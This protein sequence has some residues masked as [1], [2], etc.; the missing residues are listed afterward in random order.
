[1]RVC[2]ENSKPAC[3]EAQTQNSKSKLKTHRHVAPPADSIRSLLR[4]F[5][6]LLHAVAGREARR[7]LE[8]DA[9]GRRDRGVQAQQ[10]SRAGITAGNDDPDGSDLSAAEQG[11]RAGAAVEHQLQEEK[12]RVV[13]GLVQSRAL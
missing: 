4:P 8:T 5:V 7:L 12:R 2:G 13:P 1:V 10:W 9:G 3:R 11:S 6:R